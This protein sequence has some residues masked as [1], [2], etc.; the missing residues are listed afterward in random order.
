M[1][2]NIYCI[3]FMWAEGDMP[4]TYVYET[5]RIP[6]LSDIKGVIALTRELSAAHN[7][8]RIFYTIHKTTRNYM[9]GMVNRSIIAQA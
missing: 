9:S 5:R 4:K 6:K 8:Y 7:K 2:S 3:Y 1:K